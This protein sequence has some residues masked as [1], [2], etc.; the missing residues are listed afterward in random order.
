MV[1]IDINLHLSKFFVSGKPW[2][3]DK[4]KLKV[5]HNHAYFWNLDTTEISVY[6]EAIKELDWRRHYDSY[7]NE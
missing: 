2:Y 7:W 3:K 6:R 1:K 5:L 4:S